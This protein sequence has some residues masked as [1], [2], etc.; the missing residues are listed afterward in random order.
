MPTAASMGLGQEGLAVA[1]PGLA[2]PPVPRALLPTALRPHAS[3]VHGALLQ[4][5][6][7]GKK[8]EEPF[9]CLT[10]DGSSP[11]P[12]LNCPQPPAPQGSA[13]SDARQAPGPAA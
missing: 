9:C 7:V 13:G 4:A 1:W 3:S 10:T 11:K 2:S 8:A 6:T 12:S 5:Q